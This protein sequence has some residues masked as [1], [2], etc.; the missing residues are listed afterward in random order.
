ML[1]R[2]FSERFNAAL[3]A[4]LVLVPTF[5]PFHTSTRRIYLSQGLYSTPWPRIYHRNFSTGSLTK[6][7]LQDQQRKITGGSS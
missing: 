3:T 1:F 2:V 4:F 7:L 5:F 6:T